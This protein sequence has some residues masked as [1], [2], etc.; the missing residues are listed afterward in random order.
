MSV[1]GAENRLDHFTPWSSL[2]GGILTGVELNVDRGMA[3]L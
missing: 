2:S 3:N 1:A